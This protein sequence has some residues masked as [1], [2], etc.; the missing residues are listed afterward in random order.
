MKALVTGGGGFIG[1]AIARMLHERGDDVLVLGR[2]DYPQHDRAGI[3]TLQADLRDANAVHAA[4]K[5]VE[6]VFHVGA[7]AG[8]WGKK[9]EF[10]EIN[11]SGTASVVAACR[12]RGVEKLVFTSSPSVVFGAHDLKG[13]DETHPY[14]KRYFAHYPHTK[15]LAEQMVLAANSA[16]LPTVALRPH[17][18]WGP[19]DP[20]LIPRI[21]ERARRGKLIQVG[22]GKNL[23]DITYIDNAAVA[24]LL[25]ADALSPG[26][27]CAG[28]AYFISQGE[29]VELW[30]WLN[31]ILAALGVPQVR[32][33]ISFGAAKRIGAFLEVIHKLLPANMEPRMTRFLALQ[34][35]K[36]HYFD[37]GAAR[38]DL[39][40]VPSVSTEEGVRRMLAA[41][42]SS[43]SS[44]AVGPASHSMESAV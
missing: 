19:G 16:D 41:M 21:V 42:R 2:R 32:R 31:T 10:W 6:T 14:P 9:R 39:G 17:L 23:V 33:S 8:I 11:V 40:Y 15:V 25:A 34:L 35:A 20:H 18:V 38:R 43:D 4:C 27:C 36:S 30:P 44:V 37:I 26:G 29:P 24:H 7:L 12:A 5:G 3:P 13:V 22:D 28:R 1:S